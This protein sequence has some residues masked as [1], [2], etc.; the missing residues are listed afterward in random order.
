MNYGYVDVCSISYLVEFG[1][2]VL[3]AENHWSVGGITQQNTLQGGEVR[4]TSGLHRRDALVSGALIALRPLSAGHAR[5]GGGATAGEA[6]WLLHVEGHLV[7][8]YY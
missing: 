1:W 5:A 4:D 7:G 2:S 6:Q 8:S 3:P